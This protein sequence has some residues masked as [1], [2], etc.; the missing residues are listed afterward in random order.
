MFYIN[1]KL[2][3]RLHVMSIP[4]KI[5]DRQTDG[6]GNPHLLVVSAI[7]YGNIMVPVSDSLD[8]YPFKC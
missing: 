8:S 2:F 4:G 1:L 5:E 6:Q 3:N 7:N